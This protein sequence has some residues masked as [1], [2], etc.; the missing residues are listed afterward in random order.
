MNDYNKLVDILMEQIG[1]IQ[2]YTKCPPKKSCSSDKSSNSADILDC[3]FS[4]GANEFT[5]LATI[6]GFILANGLTVDQQNSLGSFIEQVGQ[7]IS[8]I[9][10]QGSTLQSD[11]NKNDA[12][13]QLELIKKQIKLIEKK[14]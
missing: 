4:L 8:T 2:S 13:E 1:P 14:L 11:N 3:F 9:S 12:S 5:A 10:T 7:T 6:L